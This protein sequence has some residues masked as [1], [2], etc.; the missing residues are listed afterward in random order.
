MAAMRTGSSTIS[1]LCTFPPSAF[2]SATPGTERSAG[3]ITQSS[4]LRR[5]SNVMFGASTVNMNIS[6]KGVVTGAMPPEMPGGRSALM[7]ASRSDTCW[8]AQ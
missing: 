4:R 1:K 7:L 2:T 5:S 8:R 3:R 6:P